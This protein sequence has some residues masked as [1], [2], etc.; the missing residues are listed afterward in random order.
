MLRNINLTV[1][2]NT[3]FILL[4]IFHSHFIQALMFFSSFAES[5]GTVSVIAHDG[6]VKIIPNAKLFYGITLTIFI[7]AY[8]FR[9]K[10][11]LQVNRWLLYS[12]VLIG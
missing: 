4:L 1:P 12:I 9:N 8:F 7:L 3:L 2:Y 6:T 5:F 11:P 10:I